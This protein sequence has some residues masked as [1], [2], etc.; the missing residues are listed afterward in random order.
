MGQICLAPARPE[1]KTVNFDQKRTIAVSYFEFFTKITGFSL[2]PDNPP[3]PPI[4]PCLAVSESPIL[5]AGLETGIW[6]FSFS[7]G[8]EV[9]GLM[10]K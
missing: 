1:Q 5:A 8:S 3:Y 9:P 6:L 2:L 10:L 4:Y 7:L